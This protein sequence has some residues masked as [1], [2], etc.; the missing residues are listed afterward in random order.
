MAILRLAAATAGLLAT[1]GEAVPT[2]I[3]ERCEKRAVKGFGYGEE[4]VRGVNLGG[5]FVLEPWITPSIF[6]QGPAGAVDEWT[7]TQ[8]LGKDE[9]RN[10]LEAHWSNFY[11][12]NDFAEMKS[13]GLNH[14]RIPIGY[15]SISPLAGDPYVQGA[16][17]HLATAVQWATNQ[18]LKV[19]LDLHGAPLSQN[20]F[21]NSG[22]AGPIGWTQGDS[23]KQTLAAITKLRDDFG[24]NPAVSAIELLNEPMGPQLDLNVIKQFYY[25]GWG[26][27]RDTPVATVFHDAFEGVTSWNNDKFGA[28]LTNLVLD[29]HHYEVFSSG[30]LSRSPSEHLDSACAFGGQ[31]ASTDKVTIAG[32]WSGAMTDCAKYLNGRNIGARYDGT[33][34]KDGQGSSYIG[35]CAGKSVGTV[36]GLSDADKGNVKSFVSAQISAYEKADGW[37]FWTWKNEAAPE[38]HFRNLTRAGL[39]PQPLSAASGC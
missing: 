22:H 13:Y 15:W 12:E 34:N 5:W 19:M 39:V 17:D 20:G 32:E 23:V 6:E 33:F 24:N 27:L 36:A 9:A 21:D 3:V 18:G 2:K 10:R 26:N 29:T 25:D 8:Q 37:I 4:K 31:M 7:Y 38:W 30:E 28:G 16:Y 1:F 14:V 11:N 35:N